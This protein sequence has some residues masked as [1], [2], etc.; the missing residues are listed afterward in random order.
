MSASSLLT[1]LEKNICRLS[2][3]EQLLLIERVSHRIRTDISGK[4]DIDA[5]L[6]KMAADPEI[7]KELQAIEHEFSATEQDGLDD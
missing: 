3:D 4:T 6:S 2:L 1:E 5:Q 7:Q